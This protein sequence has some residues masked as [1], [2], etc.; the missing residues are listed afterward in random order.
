MKSSVE[1]SNKVM[2]SIELIEPRGFEDQAFGLRGC[3]EHSSTQPAGL[4]TGWWQSLGMRRRATTFDM[5]RLTSSHT[6]D[7]HA[8]TWRIITKTRA[9]IRARDMDLTKQFTDAEPGFSNQAPP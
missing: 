2:Y 7:S 6:H 9:L 1:H 5:T 3:M 4:P 8:V